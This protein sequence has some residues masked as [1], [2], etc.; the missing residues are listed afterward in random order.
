MTPLANLKVIGARQSVELQAI[1]D[2]G[3]DGHLCLP[4][5][6]AVQLGLELVGE[7]VVEL[8][9]GSR[10]NEL[11]FAARVRLFDSD[12]E[13]DLMLTDSEDAL[14]GTRL[15]NHYRASIEF[16]GGRVT[17]LGESKTKRNPKRKPRR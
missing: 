7:L 17:V 15:L 16:P 12:H 1:V 8:A 14:I 13:I 2:T 6:L 11:L 4:I 9:D 3:F 5:R 10:R